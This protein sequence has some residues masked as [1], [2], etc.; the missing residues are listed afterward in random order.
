MKQDSILKELKQELGA[1]R[2][3]SN[4]PMRN[5]TSCK[6][7]GMAIYYFEAETATDLMKAFLLSYKLHIPVYILG[8]GSTVLFSDK[9]FNGFVIKNNT[10]KFDIF[11]MS[12][13]IANRKLSVDKTILYAES[14]VLTNQVVRFSIEHGFSGLEYQLGLPGTIGGAIVMNAGYFPRNVYLKDALFKIKILNCQGELK[15]VDTTYL[16]TT[17]GKSKLA[18]CEEIIVSVTFILEAKDKAQLWER[19]N[20]ASAYRATYY[21]NGMSLGLAFGDIS[22]A[23]A[24]KIPTP[25]SITSADFLIKNAGIKKKQIGDAMISSL[26]SNFITNNGNATALDVMNLFEEIK[27]SVKTKFGVSLPIQSNVIGF[28]E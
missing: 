19:G 12:G 1:H 7:G 25:Q 14:G 21:P 10:R 20:E 5:H 9:G 3:K 16:A 27:Q 11:G 6:I 23:D 15:E 22:I 24:M 28:N 26:H 8:G 18:S 13:K 4:E 17:I 2:V